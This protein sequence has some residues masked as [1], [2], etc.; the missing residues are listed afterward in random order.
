M[1][2]D[3]VDYLLQ[4]SDSN[5]LSVFIDSKTRDYVAFPSPS[6]YVVTF[7]VPIR[8][9]FGI[10]I[11]D[12]TV[13]VTAYTIDNDTNSIALTQ[14]YNNIGIPIFDAT[15]STSF[16][17]NIGLLANCP[18]F[19]SLFSAAGSSTIFCCSDKT[20]YDNMGTYDVNIQG[21][22]NGI[23]YLQSVSVNN[24]PGISGIPIDWSDGNTYYIDENAIYVQNK[25]LTFN[26]TH[27]PNWSFY[28]LPDNSALIYFEFKYCLDATAIAYAKSLGDI[29]SI[30][31]YDFIL[32]NN[33]LSIPIGNYTS[34][35]LITTLQAICSNIINSSLQQVLPTGS[36]IVPDFSDNPIPG[37]DSI[38]QAI[39]WTSGSSYPF[40][41]DM[42]KSTSRYFLGFSEHASLSKSS[43]Y[44]TFSYGSNKSIFVS[45]QL[46]SNM[47]YLHT[48]G[49][50]NLESARYIILRCPEIESHLLG[51][52]ANF[53]HS[54]GIGLFKLLSSNS[55]MSLRF[56]FVN[57]TRKPFHPIGKLS[58]L[59]IQ[60]EQYDGS[61]YDFRGIDHVLLLSIK[62]Y[63]PRNVLR[64][65]K[66]SL[67]PYYLPD[68]LE[69][70][71]KEYNN[72]S[73]KKKIEKYTLEDILEEQKQYM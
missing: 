46:S 54:P 3:D 39:T 27:D 31:T 63:A 11:L 9:V 38:T 22:T 19:D 23:F 2:I 37:S 34:Q 7:D 8:N 71:L 16:I 17:S 29:S 53:S 42:N 60:F 12:A 59:T 30:Y 66:S 35:V 72:Q 43:I 69:Y 65:P 4:N 40:F 10:E 48:P 26:S 62:Y 56:D 67:N 6:S 55:L 36:T 58:K 18:A 5:S 73:V 49:I 50:I 32:V 57:I 14:V 52:Y 45:T 64:I 68:V 33:Y 25:W 21:S 20:S 61:L 13:P 41:F 1:S 70:K 44:Q 47:Q 15:N 51:T 24:L 28:M